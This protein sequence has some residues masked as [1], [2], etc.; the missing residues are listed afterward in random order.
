MNCV[1]NGSGLALFVSSAIPAALRT[2]LAK[3]FKHIQGISIGCSFVFASRP[4]ESSVVRALSLSQSRADSLCPLEGRRAD[5]PGAAPVDPAAVAAIG[6]LDAAD[7][8]PALQ[9]KATTKAHG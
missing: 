7:A 6:L 1:H 4:S 5:G 3:L 2:R 9:T 8:V